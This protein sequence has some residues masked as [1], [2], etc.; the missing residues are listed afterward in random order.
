IPQRARYP[1]ASSKFDTDS[2]N[3]VNSIAYNTYACGPLV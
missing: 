3:P 1:F 2:E